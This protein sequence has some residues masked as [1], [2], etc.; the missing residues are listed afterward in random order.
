MKKPILLA[1]LSLS[2]IAVAACASNS[3]STNPTTGNGTGST[4]RMRH[5]T[6]AATCPPGAPGWALP[7]NII[8]DGDFHGS[9]P[10]NQD[11]MLPNTLWNVTIGDVD[12]ED[13]AEYPFAGGACSVDLDGHLPGAIAEVLNTQ[14]GHHYKVKFYLSG[15]PD[16][17]P[18]V[19]KLLVTADNGQP[20]LYHWHLNQGNARNG[21]FV[22]KHYHF[23]ATGTTTTLQF[24]SQDVYY[25]AFGPVVFQI[26][27]KD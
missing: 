9:S 6:T 25:S 12:E 2:I 18:N 21:D 15:N 3:S 22:I 17:P 20:H 23:H 1:F 5:A 8:L 7:Q 26:S 14:P 4:A 19:K 11:T 16:G 27:A 24:A 13:T 10:G